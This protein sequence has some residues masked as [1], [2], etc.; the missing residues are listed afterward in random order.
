M[1]MFQKKQK[2]NE[3]ESVVKIAAVQ[4]KMSSK[5]HDNYIE[6]I[7]YIKEAASKGAEF[8]C[9]PEGQLSHY[10]PQYEGLKLS[11]FAISM[12]HPYI[13]GIC[14][15][16][17]DCHIIA[18]ISFCLLEDDK[19][20][21]VN[22]I[23][24]QNGEVLGIGKKNHIVRM[25]HFY[26]QDYFTPGEDG[27]EVV[28]TPIGKIGMIVC[29]DRHYPESYRSCVLKGADLIIVPVA[30]EKI[31]QLEIFRWEIRIGAYQNS[32]NI[33]MCNR[34]GKEG[35]MDFCGETVF[36]DAMGEVVQVADDTEQLLIA[37]LN[38]GTAKYIREQKQY[39]PLRRPE[40][41]F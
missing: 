23:I 38:L 18:S 30:N 39:L 33:I 14:E 1:K 36:V 26:E 29:F 31:E 15:A 41:F 28:D 40:I 32:V 8:I 21:A 7:R 19:V 16:C 20:Y 25:K 12:E 34:V 11:D 35:D 22:M 3:G 5:V 17:K 10:I 24:S 4:M 13:K 27:F 2:M 6:T 9:F 37:E